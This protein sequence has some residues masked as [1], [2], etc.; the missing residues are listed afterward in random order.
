MV[1]G[2]WMYSLRVRKWSK[3][4]K[5]GH[6]VA[7]IWNFLHFEQLWSACYPLSE[8]WLSV[9]IIAYHWFSLVII[10]YHRLSLVYHGLS[11]VIIGSQILSLVIWTLVVRTWYQNLLNLNNGGCHMHAARS[12]SDHQLAKGGS[13]FVQVLQG[14]RDASGIAP[15]AGKTEAQDTGSF[16]ESQ[17]MK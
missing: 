10:G 3:D 7:V 11:L 15:Q 2:S 4:W 5:Q 8:H 1:S 17:P 13:L 14:Q 9:V 16:T 6:S 12:T